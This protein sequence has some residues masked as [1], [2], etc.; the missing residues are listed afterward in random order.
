MQLNFSSSLHPEN[1]FREIPEKCTLKMR[2]VRWHLLHFISSKQQSV[3]YL[4]TTLWSLGVWGFSE[5]LFYLFFDHFLPLCLSHFRL[6]IFVISPPFWPFTLIILMCLLYP[7]LRVTLIVCQFTNIPEEPLFW[8]FPLCFWCLQDFLSFLH[9]ERLLFNHHAITL[10]YCL[11]PNPRF[12]RL[13]G[14]NRHCTQTISRRELS[15]VVMLDRRRIS[16]FK[17]NG[18]SKLRKQI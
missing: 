15:A 17:S 14:T 12:P 16:E 4:R 8:H 7:S 5:L 10:H 6:Y 9:Y 2:G 13:S 1:T 3:P 11:R 18:G